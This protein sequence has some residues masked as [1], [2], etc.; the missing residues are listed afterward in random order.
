M[1]D[2]RLTELRDLLKG[3]Q[4][5][6]ERE[7]GYLEAMLRLMDADGNVLSRQHF[8]PG[9]FTASGFIVSS[10][11]ARVLLVHHAKLDK[12][13]QPGGHIEPED[14]GLESAARREVIEETGVP[15][16]GSMG[17][18][19]IDIHQF[20]ERGNEPAHD[21][22]DMRFGFVTASDLVEAGEGTTDVRWFTLTEVAG[23]HH[24]PSLSRPA[25]KLLR[26]FSSQ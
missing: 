7:A 20:P 11:G 21:H 5:S 22:L 13:L 25:Q 26:N 14:R 19:D 10:D 17:L 18:V 16:L 4:P 23:W 12:W 2:W 8:D 6:D 24:R 1:T 3:Y 15:D 9:H